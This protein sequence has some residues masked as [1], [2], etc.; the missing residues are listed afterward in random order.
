MVGDTRRAGVAKQQPCNRRLVGEPVVA[1]CSPV[2]DGEQRAGVRPSRVAH[3]RPMLSGGPVL[4]RSEPNLRIPGPTSLPRERREAGSRQMINHRGPEFR[5]L[6]EARPGRHEA[7]LRDDGRHRDPDVRRDRRARGGR[8]QH[9]RRAIA[10]W[11]SRSARSVTASRRS[12]RPTGPRLTRSPPSG[13]GR[14]R[15]RGPRAI[16]PAGGDSGPCCSPTTRHR[17]AS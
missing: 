5:E 10:C 13:A 7:V 14:R 15:R 2:V 12:P 4:T 3:A 11:A 17:P 8:R 1:A 16:A 6:L 9:P